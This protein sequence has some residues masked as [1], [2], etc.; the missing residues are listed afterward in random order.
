MNFMNGK[1][2]VPAGGFPQE[3]RSRVL[4]GLAPAIED[5]TR[6]GKNMKPIDFEEEAHLLSERIGVPI[7]K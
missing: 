3:F 6:P 4:K 1:L 7:Y 2:G 5:G